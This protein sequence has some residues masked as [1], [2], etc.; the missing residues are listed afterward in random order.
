[1]SMSFFRSTQNSPAHHVAQRMQFTRIRGSYDD[2]VGSNLS[3]YL[4]VQ[5][6]CRSP[7]CNRFNITS[8]NSIA[9]EKRTISKNCGPEQ[10][11]PDS[12]V[13]IRHRITVSTIHHFWHN[14]SD[15]FSALNWNWLHLIVL[16]QHKPP[17][18]NTSLP[19]TS[20]K[21]FPSDV[22]KFMLRP[23]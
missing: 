16:R 8:G 10:A 15:R 7:E 2:D 18:S 22:S 13:T 20:D 4:C 11:C 3:L 12:P 1:M 21:S 14:R 23:E 17:S 5:C 19:H 6:L 9:P